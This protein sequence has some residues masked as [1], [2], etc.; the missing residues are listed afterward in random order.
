[1]CPPEPSCHSAL[2]VDLVVNE[3]LIRCPPDEPERLARASLV[4]KEWHR[5]LDDPDFRRRYGEFHR[6]A[7]LLGLL[8]DYGVLSDHPIIQSRFVPTT[9]F[10][11][12]TPLHRRF[13]LDSRHG[14]ALY[15]T[16]VPPR[17][18]LGQ[19]GRQGPHHRRRPSG[20]FRFPPA[21]RACSL[22]AGMQQCSAPQTAATTPLVAG[23]APSS[24]PS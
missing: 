7:P 11:T 12:R 20:G 5:V 19:G 15:G 14:R 24:L 13:L 22:A 21:P 9:A 23:A 1:M 16:Y 4:C 2:L 17:A 10:S 3:I 18:C 6:R 8:H